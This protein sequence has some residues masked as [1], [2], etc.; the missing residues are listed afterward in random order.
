MTEELNAYPHLTVTP[1][2][3]LKSVGVD[4]PRLILLK[5]GRLPGLVP[6]SSSLGT[7]YHSC[8]RLLWSWKVPSHGV[9]L[10]LLRPMQMNMCTIHSH[11]SRTVDVFGSSDIW[12]TAFTDSTFTYCQF[13]TCLLL[14]RVFLFCFMGIWTF[15]SINIY[16]AETSEGKGDI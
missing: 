13:I 1:P 4:G 14:K 8:L 10:L 12:Y 6:T 15:G 16:S 11:C 3:Q 5:E 7:M 9:R 2:L